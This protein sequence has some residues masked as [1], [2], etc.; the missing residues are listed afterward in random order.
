MTVTFFGI[1]FW[2]NSQWSGVAVLQPYRS[3][4]VNYAYGQ[5]IDS[6][7]KWVTL[8]HWPEFGHSDVRKFLQSFEDKGNKK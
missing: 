1:M 6:K 3:W 4:W 2:I 5:T 8:Y 7:G